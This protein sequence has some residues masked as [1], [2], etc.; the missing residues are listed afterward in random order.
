MF[1]LAL[2]G[3]HSGSRRQTKMAT[4]ATRLRRSCRGTKEQR[5]SRPRSG[6]YPRSRLVLFS[7]SSSIYLY[8]GGAPEAEAFLVFRSKMKFLCCS[9]HSAGKSFLGCAQRMSRYCRNRTHLAVSQI[10]PM[11][12]P[13]PKHVFTLAC[14]NPTDES[15]SLSRF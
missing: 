12:S 9:W 8:M 10:T 3:P 6:K 11:H 2:F 1:E 15:F 7:K 13:K 4:M 5:M 14:C